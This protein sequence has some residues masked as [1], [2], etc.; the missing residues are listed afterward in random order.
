M[1][2]RPTWM[3]VAVSASTPVVLLAAALAAAEA[4]AWPETLPRTGTPEAALVC[5]VLALFLA[6]GPLAAFTWIHRGTMPTAPKRAG[7]ALG[8]ASGAWGAL[9]IELHCGLS[10][11]MHIALGHV[12]PV[13]V[14]AVVGAALGHWVVAFRGQRE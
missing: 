3:R 4:R 9:A 14:L 1:L 2:G 12:L 8:V 10:G 11:S 6:L 7:A 5:H 13:A